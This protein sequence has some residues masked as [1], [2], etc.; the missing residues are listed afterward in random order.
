MKKGRK[1]SGGKYKKSRKKKKYELDRN[2]RVVKLGEVKKK[3]L[4]LRGGNEK[5]VLLKSNVINVIDIKTK[6]TKKVKILKSKPIKQDKN[7]KNRIDSR[8]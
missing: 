2:P 7:L 3:T 4:S 6:K 1:I 5:K 8:P